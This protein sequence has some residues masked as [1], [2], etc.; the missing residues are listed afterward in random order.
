M[1][2][3]AL[4]LTW[5][6]AL[7]SGLTACDPD[8]T[9][10][11][12]DP[13]TVDTT[14][15]RTRANPFEMSGGGVEGLTIQ[16]RGGV[17]IAEATVGADG[18]WTAMVM[19]RADA[20]NTLLV[21]QTDGTMES[22]AVTRMVTHDGTAPRT[23]TL[24]AS[25][26]PTRQPTSRIR[27]TTEPGATVLVSGG[28]TDAMGNADAT[29]RF[30]VPVML[31]TSATAAITNELSV[32]ARDDV[33]NESGIVP[34]VITFDPT[35]AIEA[36]LVDPIAPTNM[37]NVNV[38][39]DAEMGVT[40]TI[41]G[42]VSPASGTAGADGSFSIP[43]ELQPNVANTLFVFAVGGGETSAAATLVVI[44]DDIAPSSPELDPIASPT[45]L[46]TVSVG[47]LSE[48]GATIAVAGGASAASG[49][50]DGDGRFGVLAD[51]TEDVDNMLEV[52]ATD[53]A[54]NASEPA[55]LTLTQD[56]SLPTPVLVNPVPSPTSINPVM[57]TGSTEPGAIVQI[58]GGPSMVEA[59]ASASGSFM[60]EVT[61]FANAS[62]E[63]HVRRAGS[64]ADTILVIVHDDIAPAAPSVNS[65]PSPTGSTSLVV[66]GT[67]EPFVRLSVTGGT[68][69]VTGNAGA[70]AGFSLPVSIAPNA[71]ATL[72]VV[73]T[74]RAGNSSPATTIMIAHSSSTPA[75]P[76]L[77]VAAPAP[78]MMA[79]YRVTGRVPSPAAGV[80]VMISGGAAAASGPT[81]PSTGIFGIDVTL[82]ANA[83]NTLDAVSMAGAI[84]SA[85][86]RVSIVHD[87]IAPTA[88]DATHLDAD[89]P[90]I[91]LFRGAVSTV[92]T[93]GAVEARSSV[94]VTNSDTTTAVT[95]T[96]SDTGTFTVNVVACPGD[97]LSV[98]ATDA[99]GNTSTATTF[100]VR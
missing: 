27:G 45:S 40:I 60:A 74:D 21:S 49:S 15:M 77:D 43:V 76:I 93:A 72:I 83:V 37:V 38:T 97:T 64:G 95:T 42:A 10:E 52:V 35:L 54:G 25:V 99:A 5:I 61:L 50:A 28:L 62:N 98:T 85:P 79:T 73:A 20:L 91:C 16:I 18:R 9:V 89:G 81:D 46:T 32:R 31:M 71:T 75:A 94:R 13:P 88:P 51:L 96:A 57:L 63:L 1:A 66:S 90:G 12:I 26:S 6:L 70:D 2:K 92:G 65:I 19:L 84:T 34:V 80:T 33:G 30:E 4:F 39:G 48:A 29:G 68:A 24:D 100:D 82:N 78:T 58:V 14:V 87:D 47:G 17:E 23:P 69:A 53:A 56:S 55:L 11:M 59:T 22:S 86:A 8:P 3:R 44:H 67:S 36:P 7:T 41:A